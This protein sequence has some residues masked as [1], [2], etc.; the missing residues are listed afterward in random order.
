[1][2]TEGQRRDPE[3][4]AEHSLSGQQPGRECRPGEVH[5]LQGPGRPDGVGYRPGVGLQERE[6]QHLLGQVERGPPV[7]PPEPEG[8]GIY[9]HAPGAVDP[10]PGGPGRTAPALS[11]VAPGTSALRRTGPTP[12]GEAGARGPDPGEHPLPQSPDHRL[13]QGCGGRDVPGIGPFRHRPGRGRHLP[14]RVSNPPRPSRPRPSSW[15]IPPPPSRSRPHRPRV[16]SGDVRID[17][18]LWD[19]DQGKTIRVRAP[20]SISAES[21][22]R[23]LQ[24]SDSW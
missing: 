18:R 22:E 14:P 9:P 12:G 6:D 23:F 21:F 2:A 8:R 1:M 11:P 20:E 13:G 10:A 24:A 3:A 15:R 19:A 16:R 7:R 5:R 17:V 4:R